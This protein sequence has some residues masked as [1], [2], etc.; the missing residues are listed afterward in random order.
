IG[1]T[2]EPDLYIVDEPFIGLDPR[3]TKNLLQ[4]LAQER[5]RGAAV[6]MSTHVLDTAEKIC[7]R[8]LI[9]SAGRLIASGDLESIREQAGV[10]NASLLDCFDRLT[11][12]VR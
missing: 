1:L 12:D 9:V 10:A 3:A 5:E 7:D 4:L 11:E 6:L 8:F 2:L